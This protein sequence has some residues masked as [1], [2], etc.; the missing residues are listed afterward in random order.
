MLA[1][2]AGGTGLIRI[3]TSSIADNTNSCLWTAGSS[4]PASLDF[5]RPEQVY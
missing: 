4:A 2:E 3:R 5:A 1:E